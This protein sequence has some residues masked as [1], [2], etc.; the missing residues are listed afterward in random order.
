MT[1]KNAYSVTQHEPL[2]TKS[3]MQHLTNYVKEKPIKGKTI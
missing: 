1:W 3:Y 2:D